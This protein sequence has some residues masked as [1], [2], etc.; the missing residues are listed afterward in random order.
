MDVDVVWLQVW[1]SRCFGNVV[2][3]MLVSSFTCWCC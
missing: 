2:S 1:I 3:V